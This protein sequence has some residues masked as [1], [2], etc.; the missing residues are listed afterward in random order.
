MDASEPGGQ[1]ADDEEQ[2]TRG[3]A[4][5]HRGPWDGTA[6][7][8]PDDMDTARIPLD[9]FGRPGWLALYVR[10]YVPATVRGLPPERTDVFTYRGW[11]MNDQ[12]KG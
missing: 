9:L 10:E 7:E 6:T 3:T 11:E 2:P 1:G 8:I 5:M 4:V 12:P